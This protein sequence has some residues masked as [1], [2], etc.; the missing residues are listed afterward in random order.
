[1]TWSP[2]SITKPGSQPFPVTFLFLVLETDLVLSGPLVATLRLFDKISYYG[3]ILI[4]IW[5][6]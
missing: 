1:M 2:I 5:L 6:W 3:S 4:L